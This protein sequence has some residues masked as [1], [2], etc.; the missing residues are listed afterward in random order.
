MTEKQ[1]KLLATGLI[2]LANIV[3]GALVFGQFISSK[4]FD[5]LVYNIGALAAVALYT[6]AIAL[7]K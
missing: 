3:A 1:R 7:L 5:V 4:E 2:E 6:W